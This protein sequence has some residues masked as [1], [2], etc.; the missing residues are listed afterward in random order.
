MGEGDGGLE[1]DK[2]AKHVRGNQNDE[3]SYTKKIRREG[4]D[5]Q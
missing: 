1:K 2:T 5:D 3:R 4:G